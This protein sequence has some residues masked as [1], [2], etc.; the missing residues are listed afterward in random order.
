MDVG[1]GQSNII[2]RLEFRKNHALKKG[3]GRARHAD[4]NEFFRHAKGSASFYNPHIKGAFLAVFLLNFERNA[5]VLF[6]EVNQISGVNIKLL[7]FAFNKSEAF[8]GV[9]KLYI[10]GWHISVYLL[11]SDYFGLPKVTKMKSCFYGLKSVLALPLVMLFA[12]SSPE[13]A[14]TDEPAATA[15]HQ[16]KKLVGEWVDTSS[17]NAFHEV[18]K[19]TGKGWEGTGVVLEGRDTVWIEHL[20]IA[21]RANR[22]YYGV[23]LGGANFNRPVYFELSSFSDNHFLFENPQHDFPQQIHY[24]FKGD[25]SLY[26]RIEG[27]EADTARYEEFFMRRADS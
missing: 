7:A 17:Q 9:E 18:W 24:E 16:F 3:G 23:T 19:H 22:W 1:K 4:M 5:V 27:V 10:S 20:E 6:N 8:G 2:Q 14:K 15:V 12:C 11:R 26:V 21:P 25:D 13:E